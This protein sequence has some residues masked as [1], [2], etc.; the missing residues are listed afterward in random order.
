M[1]TST[2]F[3]TFFAV[4]VTLA[5][6]SWQATAAPLLN[7]VAVHTELGEEQFIAGLYVDS[8][9]TSASQILSADEN[10]RVQ[11]RVLAEGLSSRRF[12]RMWI[13]GMAINSSRE[14][15]QK[16]AQTMA[17]FSNMLRVK[18]VA[19]DIM[20]IDRSMDEGVTISLNGTTL[21]KIEDRTFFDL[22]LRTWIGSVPLSSSFRSNLLSNGE[23]S[24]ELFSRYESTRPTDARIATIESAIAASKQ[25]KVAQR[26][27]PQAVAMN[28]EPPTDLIQAPKLEAPTLAMIP[29]PVM[30]KP[31]PKKNVPEKPKVAAKPKPAAKNDIFEDEGEEAF[32]AASL[33]SRQLYIGKVKGWAQ[34]ELSYPARA[35][36]REWEGNV[37][38]DITLDRRGDLINV[39]LVEEAEHSVLNK[40]ALRAVQDAAP[41]P[42]MPDD[43]KG[44]SFL[45][46]LPVAFKLQ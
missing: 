37:R 9:S 29:P 21:G 41:F 26:E 2:R 32:T 7:G 20:T 11:V 22:L 40:E 23:V 5:L 3:A 15:L 13:E 14:D 18:L 42:P 35:L 44:D 12:K 28:T 27:K 6:S 24:S 34:R 17:D 8:P 36:R 25:E 30:P 19:G 1:L 31:T 46:T 43:V 16:N 38:L 4:A 33:L 39:E 45:F 10:K